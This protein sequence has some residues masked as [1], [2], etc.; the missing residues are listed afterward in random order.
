MPFTGLVYSSLHSYILFVDDLFQYYAFKCYQH[1]NTALN[2][3]ISVAVETGSSTFQ[4]SWVLNSNY[5][6][7]RNGFKN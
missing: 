1:L 7:G 2:V 4:R 3:I 6:P 5:S